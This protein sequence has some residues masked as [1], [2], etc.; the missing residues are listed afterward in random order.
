MAKQPPNAGK[1]WTP[2]EVKQLDQLAKG[3]TPTR[4][5]GFKLGRQGQRISMSLKSQDFREERRVH[6]TTD[7]LA[8][9][10]VFDGMTLQQ[11]HR[12]AS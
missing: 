9:E 3:N 10:A 12:K 6:H 4:V 7:H 1:R 11:G 8:S 5:I 2:T